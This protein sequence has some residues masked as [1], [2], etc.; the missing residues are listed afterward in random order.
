M[1]YIYGALLL[2]S[3]G[4]QINEDGLKKVLEAAGVA[5]E[6]ARVKAVVTSL[7]GVNI[8]E[9]MKTAIAA[10]VASAPAAASAAPAEEK[11]KKEEKKEEEEAGPTEEEAMAGLG[12]LF[13]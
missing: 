11:K 10:P 13:G 5:V 9:A 2:H 4:K 1:E 3:A 8:E 6:P 7:D 12:A